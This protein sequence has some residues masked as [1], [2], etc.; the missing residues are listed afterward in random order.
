MWLRGGES[1]MNDRLAGHQPIALV[2]RD[3]K[4][5]REIDA[6][7]R[8]VDARRSGRVANISAASPSQDAG[9]IDVLAVVGKASG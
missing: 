6:G 8:A 4:A 1:V 3:S 5:A 2:I 9:F 7:W